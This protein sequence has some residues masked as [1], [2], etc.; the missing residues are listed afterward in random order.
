MNE[1]TRVILTAMLN[2]KTIQRL[3]DG[4]WVDLSTE[5]VMRVCAN[6]YTDNPGGSNPV[7]VK[8]TSIERFFPVF[9]TDT[10]DTVFGTSS[11]TRA[12]A[13]P[14]NVH[15]NR[16]QVGILRVE[17]DADSLDVMSATMEKRQP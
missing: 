15:L 5:G 11:S 4:N 12:S 17:I 16:V 8:P 13:N 9:R 14:L 10:N 3:V 1:N 6:G 7:R 2:G